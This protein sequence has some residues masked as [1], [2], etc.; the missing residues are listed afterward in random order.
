MTWIDGDCVPVIVS[1][2]W[3]GSVSL[4][5]AV[6]V[7]RN[8]PLSMSACVIVCVPVQTIES[9]IASVAGVSG[10][11]SYPSS[12]GSSVTVT[13]VSATLPVFFAVRRVRDDLTGM[14]VLERV[15]VVLLRERQRRQ[16]RGHVVTHPNC[17]TL[18]VVDARLVPERAGV[19]VLLLDRVARAT[20]DRRT[21]CERIDRCGRIALE[22]ADVR[23]GDI[24]VR[25][26][27]LA[28]V[29]RDDRVMDHVVDL[30]ERALRRFL[31]DRRR[32]GVVTSSQTCAAPLSP[33]STQAWL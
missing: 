19:D 32:R 7:S 30:A 33:S 5:S 31:R 4:L 11:H 15:E 3:I 23:I 18:A 26:R 2:V 27:R 22:I 28:T 12:A 10:M 6:A 17:P 9:P 8:V 20:R 16:R 25:Q 13:L 21:G 1:G 24:D 14:G 29:R